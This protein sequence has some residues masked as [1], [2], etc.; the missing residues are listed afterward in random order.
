VRIEKKT[1]G[2]GHVSGLATRK[3]DLRERGRDLSGGKSEERRIGEKQG[4]PIR[5]KA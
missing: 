3:R 4:V 1:Q 5:G 2:G